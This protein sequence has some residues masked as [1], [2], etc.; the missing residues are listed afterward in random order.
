MLE[1]KK[2]RGQV[3]IDFKDA[4]KPPLAIIRIE[5]KFPSLV[6]VMKAG[7]IRVQLLETDRVD[8]FHFAYHLFFSNEHF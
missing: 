7:L 8:F 2:S 1:W 4:F 6:L 3:V 5:I